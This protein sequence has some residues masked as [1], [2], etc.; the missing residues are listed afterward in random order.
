LKSW[1]AIWEPTADGD[2]KVLN[3]TA[4]YYR[5]FDATPQ[6]EFLYSCVKK[7]IEEDLPRET[8]FLHRH[9]Q[10]RAQIEEIIDMPNRTSDLLLQFLRQNGGR[11]SQRARENEFAKMTD[12]EVATAE[13]AYVTAFADDQ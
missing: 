12:A 6:A 5:F 3:D 11:L 9:D 4:D 2:V 13:Q 8:D 1:C 10:F 7:T